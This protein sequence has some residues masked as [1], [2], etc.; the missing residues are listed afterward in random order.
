M[1]V[2]DDF[3]GLLLQTMLGSA[4]KAAKIAV[5]CR[6]DD[7][8]DATMINRKS[9]KIKGNTV[10]ADSV[11]LA[12]VLIQETI[13]LDLETALPQLRGNVYGEES[14]MF[15]T[16]EGNQIE[17]SCREGQGQLSLLLESVIGSENYELSAELAAIVY[18][19][20]KRYSQEELGCNVPPGMITDADDV[21][22]VLDPLDA[23]S[24]YL[25]GLMNGASGNVLED[26]A[27]CLATT[28]ILIGAF[29]ISTGQPVCGVAMQPFSTCTGNP[30]NWQSRVFWG[31]LERSGENC[32][33]RLWGSI[34][35][36]N[37]NLRDSSLIVHSKS[38]SKE[39]LHKLQSV[40]QCKV[41]PGAGFKILCVVRRLA[42]AF[43]LSLPT[44]YAWDTCGPHAIV[45]A[46]GGSLVDSKGEP[47]T[48]RVNHSAAHPNGILATLDS[49]T[50]NRILGVLSA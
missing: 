3:G 49:A 5:R 6:G 36:S 16:K 29:R 45:E 22:V 40:G 7:V 9:D 26:E 8:F 35:N 38:E 42:K 44:T 34:P 43:V 15:Y 30:A 11:T 23:T 50:A 14:G 41:V 17:I 21:A 28:T 18:S 12:D 46:M 13:Q 47:I 25:K 32:G 39:I 4:N 2:T 33:R 31:I 48:Y 27:G 20:L 37:H 1:S 19:P 24:K 10:E